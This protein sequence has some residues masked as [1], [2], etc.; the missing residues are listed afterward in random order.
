MH[1]VKVLWKRQIARLAERGKEVQILI[2]QL[3]DDC[4]E[5]II[6]IQHKSHV[7]MIPFLL[8]SN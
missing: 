8:L 4:V 5:E 6:V 3:T 2:H 1:F 7:D